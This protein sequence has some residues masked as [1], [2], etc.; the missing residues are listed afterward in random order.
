MQC[1]T[2]LLI[3]DDNIGWHAVGQ[4]LTAMP[5]LRT[6]VAADAA[7]A[8]ERATAQPPSAIVTASQLGNQSAFVLLA[9]LRL[10]LPGATFVVIAER[11]QPDELLRISG[12]GIASYLLWSD[13]SRT[14]LA[15]TLAAAMSGRFVLLS[16]AVSAAHIAAER[17][18]YTASDAAPPITVRE[19]A[20]LRGLAEGL[21]QSQIARV[22]D[23]SVST[24]ARDIS[25]LAEKFDASDRFVLGMKAAGLGLVP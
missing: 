6:V 8:W 5:G 18:R 24:V 23:V 7:E 3:P 22:E 15:C 21:T 1:R 14:E 13:L 25:S 19:R 16:N 9:R 17:G 11:H 4:A 10:V 20:V 12:A 2:V